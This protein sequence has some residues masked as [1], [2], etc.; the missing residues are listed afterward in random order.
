MKEPSEIRGLNDAQKEYAIRVL[1]LTL[2]NYMKISGARKKELLLY[3]GCNL[4]KASGVSINVCHACLGTGK[5][6]NTR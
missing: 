2:D 1:S 4:A 5:N 6:E 3:F